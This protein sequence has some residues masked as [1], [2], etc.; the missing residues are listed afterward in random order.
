[1]TDIICDGVRF[2]GQEEL[3]NGISGFYQDLYKKVEP[4]NSESDF[5]DKCPSLSE[6]S[7]E[8]IFLSLVENKTV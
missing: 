1:M 3:T 8:F 5:Y 4:N 2:R 7:K 6:Q